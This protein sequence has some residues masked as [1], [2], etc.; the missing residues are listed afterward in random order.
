MDW[1]NARMNSFAL[2][3]A[4]PKP[5]DSVL[6]IGFGG[7]T[8]PTLLNKAGFVAG[9]DRSPDVIRLAKAKYLQAINAGRARFLEG[10]VE[11]LPFGDAS[12]TKVLT[13]NTVYFW[14]SLDEGLSE[15]RRVLKPT[16]RAMIG[17]LP[18]VHMQKMG[19]P[20]DL[21]TL[22]SLEEVF[23]ALNRCGFHEVEVQRPDAST[24]WNVIVAALAPPIRQV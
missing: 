22:R 18:R 1:H 12:F 20:N 5:D 7:K 17:F 9:V 10:Q 3:V 16:G 13:V 23:S 19:M 2:E 4:D 24:K 8:M 15:I 14:R 21:F 11:R 6:E